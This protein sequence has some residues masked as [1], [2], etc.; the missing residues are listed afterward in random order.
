[1]RFKMPRKYSG[2]FLKVLLTMPLIGAAYGVTVDTACP[3]PTVDMLAIGDAPGGPRTTFCISSYGWSN[4]WF[5]TNNPGAAPANADINLLG[6]SA[7]Y[8]S[9]DIGGTTFTS[10][11]TPA[12]SIGPVSSSFTEV[13]AVHKL[14]NDQAQ[15]EIT[16]SRVN[17]SID[18][19]VIRD[20]I[21]MTFTIL[22][23]TL[24]PIQNI[25]FVQYLNY[26]P[27]G[28][29]NPNLGTLTYQPVP[30]LEDTY[31]LGLWGAG[32]PTGVPLVR[33]GGVCGGPGTA[34]CS[35]P[36]AHD[37]GAPTDVITD[38]QSGTFNGVN[39]SS[40]NVAGALAWNLS[41]FTLQPGQTTQ[42]TIELV[43]EPGSLALILVGCLGL[44]VWRRSTR[45]AA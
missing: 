38:I 7:Q 20:N 24:S 18:S 29:T 27:H 3:T 17:I 30:T 42:F 35:T 16:D 26:F 10:W 2:V 5:A 36:D 40:N 34:G 21:R 9:Y 13:T 23:N 12:L 32:S 43:P 45:K 4:G 22:N 14:N 25:M 6:D 39:S 41:G 15:S 8:L 37:I 31:V 11:L 1:M 33:E 28:S 19:Q 44:L